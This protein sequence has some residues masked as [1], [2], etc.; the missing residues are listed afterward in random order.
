MEEQEGFLETMLDQI[1][2]GVYI[3]N[4][5][6]DFIFVNKAYTEIVGRARESCLKD[7]AFRLMEKGSL[8]K[9]VTQ[10]VFEQNREVTTFQEVHTAGRTFRQIITSTP[11]FDE[12]GTIQNVIAVMQPLYILSEKQKKAIMSEMAAVA[13]DGGE[14]PE[15]EII[16]ESAKMRRILELVESVAAF[17]SP[18]MLCGESGV[19]K[20]IIARQ[21]HK[22]SPRSEKDLVVVNCAELPENLLEAELFGYEKGAFTG[23]LNTGKKGIIEEAMGSTLFLDEI[24]SLPLP[25]QGKLLRVLD[26]KMV[27]RIGSNRPAYVDFR[28]VTATN[29]NLKDLID[30]D[31]FRMDLY[32]RMN[33]VPI[34][35]PPLRERVEDIVPL[36]LY[37]LKQF[38]DKYGR[39]KIFSKEIYENMLRYQ[40][41]G[42]VRELKN[43]V[44]R[45]LVMSPADAVELSEIPPEILLDT[46][47]NTAAARENE[48]FIFIEQPEEY[49]G[50]LKYEGKD[51]SLKTYLEH[52]EKNIIEQLLLKYHST[53][54]VAELLKIN[55][56]NI[57]RKKGKYQI[58]Y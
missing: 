20:E 18:V 11:V 28:L 16:F 37:F 10:M 55:Q 41:P 39:N 2:E 49:G 46:G 1:K 33:V 15:Q 17:D 54:K 12:A 21:I 34:Y 48:T 14:P 27:K 30:R 31:K 9:C 38:C 58:E 8:S 50:F 35:I 22:K 26:T 25:L 23:A 47:L 36:G 52:C 42:N 29:K 4:G 53:Y 43:F 13:Y 24:D 7:N 19:G 45:M 56:S 57:A 6:G 44:E 51:F 5:R 32:Y 3:L 40:W